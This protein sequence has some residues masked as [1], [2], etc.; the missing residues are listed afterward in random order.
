LNIPKNISLN[1]NEKAH[2]I[3]FSC[4]ICGRTFAQIKSLNR[5][6]RKHKPF[7]C[8]F[9]GKGFSYQAELSRHERIHTG[10]KPFS[11]DLCGQ[12]FSDNSGLNSHKKIHEDGK[13]F[14]CV[15]CKKYFSTSADLSKHEMSE[16]HLRRQGTLQVIPQEHIVVCNKPIKQEKDSFSYLEK[17]GNINDTED[18][19][20]SDHIDIEEFK[21]E[22]TQQNYVEDEPT[23]ESNYQE[24]NNE[25]YDQEDTEEDTV[26][27]EMM[28]GVDI[29]VNKVDK[30]RVEEQLETNNDVFP[31]LENLSVEEALAFFSS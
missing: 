9:C 10:L 19:D 25:N 18:S 2:K 7:S 13:C 8:V 12:K 1:K 24:D 26:N 11:C 28:I 17:T 30:N 29:L 14:S 6:K 23:K 20:V 31:T 4:D 16:A 15:T 3:T 5:H 27:N 21:L 22:P